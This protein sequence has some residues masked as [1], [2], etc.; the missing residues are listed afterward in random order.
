MKN[1]KHILLF[2]LAF[3]IGY[4][5]LLATKSLISKPEI[6]K[7]KK[8][9]TVPKQK[10]LQ[11]PNLEVIEE[12]TDWFEGSEKPYRMSLLETG[13]HN[14]YDVSAHSGENWLGLF[15]ENNRYVLKR[16]KLK[17]RR[18]HQDCRGE[19]KSNKQGKDVGITG[20]GK[21]EFLIKDS[22]LSEGKVKTFFRGNRWVE[23]PEGLGMSFDKYQTTLEKGFSQEYEF[24]GI[25]YSLKVIEVFSKKENYKTLALVLEGDGIRQI[26]H[27][28]FSENGGT[29][30]LYWAGDLD[31]D[32]RPDFYIGFNPHMVIS[33]GLLYLSLE[34]KANQLAKLAA[35]YET[36]GC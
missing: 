22:G 16:T 24:N 35:I 12:V 18:V 31:R 13:Y 25:W 19:G 10:V 3:T 15:R 8:S 21:P 11:E 36:S 17:I 4:S 23:M 6:I 20:N 34:S 14:E 5:S 29:G 33:V 27:T 7:E 1:L 2:L 30:I 26:L 9:L 32:E 28:G